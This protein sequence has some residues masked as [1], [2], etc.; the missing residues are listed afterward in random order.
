M[1]LLSEFIST[2]VREKGVI[3]HLMMDTSYFSLESLLMRLENL[4]TVRRAADK[5]MM[6]FT[7]YY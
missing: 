1:T 2:C 6:I 4:I 7:H 5:S 3:G